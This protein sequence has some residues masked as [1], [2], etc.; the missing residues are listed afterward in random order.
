MFKLSLILSDLADGNSVSYQLKPKDSFLRLIII[1]K[2]TQIFNFQNLQQTIPF[3]F[4][5]E[6]SNHQNENSKFQ[7]EE[8]HITNQ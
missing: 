5:Y 2:I 6:K 7:N 8:N 3:Y 1:F 4:Q